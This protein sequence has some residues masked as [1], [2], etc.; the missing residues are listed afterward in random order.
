MLD[1]VARHP[2]LRPPHLADVLLLHPGVGQVHVRLQ[3]RFPSRRACARR[4]PPPPRTCSQRWQPL[5]VAA[6]AGT[7][8]RVPRKLLK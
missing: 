7:A 5:A 4:D 3:G 1:S 2:G 6:A 8:F